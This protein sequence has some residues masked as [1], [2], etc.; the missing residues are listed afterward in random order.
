VNTVTGADSWREVGA[1]RQAL[2]ISIRTRRRGTNSGAAALA[3][4]AGFLAWAGWLATTLFLFFLKLI[5]PFSILNQNLV[6]LAI[7][8]A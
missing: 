2:P 1:D 4:W 6:W 8:I 3:G 7:K 5:F